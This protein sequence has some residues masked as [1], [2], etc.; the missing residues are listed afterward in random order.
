MT[1]IEKGNSPMVKMESLQ[2]T[3]IFHQHTLGSSHPTTYPRYILHITILC[4]SVSSGNNLLNDLFESVFVAFPQNLFL[5]VYNFIALFFNAHKPLI[6]FFKILTEI[7]KYFFL[8]A[9]S[10]DLVYIVCLLI[11]IL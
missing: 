10:R 11:H 3:I 7:N 9:K 5:L 2:V 8:I 1:N 4:I 6:V